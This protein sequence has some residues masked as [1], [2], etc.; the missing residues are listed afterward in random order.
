MKYLDSFENFKVN[1]KLLT[2]NNIF[3]YIKTK[4]GEDKLKDSL[5][6]FKKNINQNKDEYKE[7]IKILKN[8]NKTGYIDKNDGKLIMTKFYDTLKLL[9][10]SGLFILPFGSFGII[11]L[12]KIAE[13]LDIN[14]LP[15]SWKKNNLIMKYLKYFEENITWKRRNITKKLFKKT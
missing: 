11:A 6:T 1:E 2:E 15:S 12:L 10:L 8:Y 7:V 4:V 13:K 3:D 5:L 14:I 9:G